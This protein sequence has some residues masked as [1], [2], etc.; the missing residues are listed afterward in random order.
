M[1]LVTAIDPNIRDARVKQINT[2]FLDRTE[3]SSHFEFDQRDGSHW[4]IKSLDRDLPNG[5]PVW[6]SFLYT[7]DS[8]MGGRS[9]STVSL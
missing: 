8:F 2:H 9:D 5:Y 7:K 3:S 6:E 4:T 1:I